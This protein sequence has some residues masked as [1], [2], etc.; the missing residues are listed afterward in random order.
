MT[1]HPLQ[2]TKYFITLLRLHTRQGSGDRFITLLPVKQIK[3]RFALSAHRSLINFNFVEH[4]DTHTYTDHL[5]TY[6][7]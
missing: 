3:Q 4:T 6:S 5:N 1:Y 7:T 2:D